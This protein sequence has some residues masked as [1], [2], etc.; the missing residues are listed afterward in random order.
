MTSAWGDRRVGLGFSYVDQIWWLL[1]AVCAVAALP[2]LLLLLTD[3]R[4]IAGAN[5]W[6]KPLKFQISLAVHMATLALA[7]ALLPQELR[8]SWLFAGLVTIAAISLLGE[9][10]YITLQG[11]RGEPSHFNVTTPFHARMYTLMGIG[12]LLL[13]LP[14]LVIGLA[15]WVK[16]PADLHPAVRDAV[17]LGFVGGALLTV[18]VAGHIGSRLSPFVGTEPLGAPRWPLAGWSR[19]VGDLRISHFAATH[20][21]Q[22]V[23]LAGLAI[24]RLVPL[25]VARPAVWL[26]ALAWTVATL[27]LYRLALAGTPIWRA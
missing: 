8:A 15:L 20:M 25:P 11:A 18:L 5:V 13:L 6:A 2:T 21:L 4:A 17:A 10:S 7:A 22:G 26:F 24:A 23:P 27:W 9:V 1:A 16:P 14:A 3:P 19:S 12:A